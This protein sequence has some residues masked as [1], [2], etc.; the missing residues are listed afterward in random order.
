MRART[1]STLLHRQPHVAFGSFGLEES[2]AW[3]QCSVHASGSPSEACY[4]AR[5]RKL[6]CRAVGP[7]SLLQGI[8]QQEL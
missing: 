4:A 1:G 6:L 3:D 5:G 2:P 8:C 7:A